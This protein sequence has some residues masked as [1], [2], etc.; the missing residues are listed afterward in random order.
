MRSVTLPQKTAAGVLLC[1]LLISVPF[2]A[3]RPARTAVHFDNSRK[4]GDPPVT[5]QLRTKF[6]RQRGEVLT[7]MLSPDDRILVPVTWNKNTELWDTET[8]RLITTVAGRLIRPFSYSDFKVVGAFSPDGHTLMTIGGKEASLWDTASGKLKQTLRGHA[9]NIRA[10][11]FS[12]DGNTIATASDDGTAKLWN[13]ETGQVKATLDAYNV[14]KYARWR[15]V[16]RLLARAEVLVSFSADGKRVLTAAHDQLTR[17]WDAKTGR[18]IAVMSKN[19]RGKFSPS[20]RFI[21]TQRSDFTGTE[22]WEAETGKL[23]VTME[24]G[25]AAFS[26]NEQWLG[27][28]GYQGKRGLLNLNTLQVEKPL[29]LNLNDFVTW[30]GFSPDSETFVLASGLH[31]HTAALVDTSA[32]TVIADI[33]IVAKEGFDFVSDYLKY[34]EQLSFHPSSRF[35]MGANQK[36]VRFWDTKSGQPITVINE[37]RDPAAFSGNGKFLVTTDKDKK[38]LSLWDV[39][40]PN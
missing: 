29:S 36:L 30:T 13:P 4:P 31:Q 8:G 37:A 38:S 40:T 20:G 15:V 12:H 16:S 19:F 18:L 21:F 9:G 7:V 25:D 2:G 24:G 6:P 32:G 34:A 27:F 14:K 35:L 11:T 17:L 10:A 5:F 39:K 28:I 22:L 23:K 3:V 26:P 1:L 33:P